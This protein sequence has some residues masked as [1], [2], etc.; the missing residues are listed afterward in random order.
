MGTLDYWYILCILG[1]VIS[2]VFPKTFNQGS[3]MKLKKVLVVEDRDFYYEDIIKGLDGKVEVVWAQTLEEG[4]QCFR[5]YDFDLIIM[6]ACLEEDWP[7]S[8]PLVKKI[9]GSGYKRPIIAASSLA[10]YSRKLV[11][12]G[13][14][15]Q[16]EK[17]EAGH[18]ALELLGL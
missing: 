5:E 11:E 7:D 2:V 16:A 1:A 17:E 3:I 6:D 12:A 13:A 4:E 10:A 9:L 8:M 14:T 15:H 18:L